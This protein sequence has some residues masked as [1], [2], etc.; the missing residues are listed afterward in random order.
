MGNHNFMQLPFLAEKTRDCICYERSGTVRWY[1]LTRL[2]ML[3]GK[4]AQL[5]WDLLCLLSRVVLT[6]RT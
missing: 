5:P 6:Q 3:I 2:L 4:W 1:H